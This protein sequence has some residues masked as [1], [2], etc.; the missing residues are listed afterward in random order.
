[1][2]RFTGYAKRAVQFH[3]GDAIARD[4][5]QIN[6]I[7]PDLQAGAGLVEDRTC[8]GRN[9]RTAVGAGVFLA[10]CDAM[11]RSVHHTALGASMTEAKPD[12]HH[13]V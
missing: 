1:M 12:L 4:G 3:A 7:E 2:A 13:M 11:E 5:E 9:V 10:I 8:A 6:P